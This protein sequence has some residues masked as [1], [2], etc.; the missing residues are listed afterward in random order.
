MSDEIICPECGAANPP[1]STWCNKDGSL[2]ARGIDGSPETVKLQ[3]SRRRGNAVDRTRPP[4]VRISSPTE[5]IELVDTR[6]GRLELVVDNGAEYVRRLTLSVPDVDRHLQIHIQ[7]RELVLKPS[8]RATIELH[9]TTP[10]GEPGSVQRHTVTVVAKEGGR[11]VARLAVVF[12]QRISASPKRTETSRPMDTVRLKRPARRTT[13]DPNAFPTV[14]AESMGARSMDAPTAAVDPAALDASYAG[15]PI[16]LEPP[17]IRLDG[18]SQA[19]FLVVADNSLGRETLSVVL[20]QGDGDPSIDY[21]FRPATFEVPPA[22]VIAG[23]L[24]V[25]APPTRQNT[26]E[27]PVGVR[28]VAGTDSVECS[29]TVVQSGSPWRWFAIYLLPVLGAVVAV[30]GSVSPLTRA[31]NFYWFNAAGRYRHAGGALWSAEPT[32]SQPAFRIVIG[33]LAIVMVFGLFLPR[34]LVTRVAA[35]LL[36]AA[37]VSYG[38]YTVLLSLPVNIGGMSYGF[39]LVVL[40]AVLGYV[41]GELRQR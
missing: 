25:T 38:V 32:L 5:R 9:V 36:F 33:V 11:P 15:S 40:G 21:E 17:S 14:M 10:P 37:A 31:A 28:A 3:A 20:H 27:R 39:Y 12:V 13:V 2:L 1:G 23:T 29:G 8:Q 22:Q 18:G 4:G 19:T 34:G 24:I 7:P 30:L 41:A 35:A 16:R 26:V 6:H